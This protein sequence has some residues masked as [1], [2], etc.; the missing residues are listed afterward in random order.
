MLKALA[1]IAALGGLW[2]ALFIWSN[3]TEA[4]QADYCLD[5]GGVWNYDLD[6]CEGA[7]PSYKGP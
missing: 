4:G 1:T 3:Y 6:R 5:E 2:A 7:R